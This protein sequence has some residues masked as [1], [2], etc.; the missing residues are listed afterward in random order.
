L[1]PLTL[2]AVTHRVAPFST[3]E[4]V[5]LDA[6]AAGT[7]AVSLRALPGVDEAV[8]LSTCNRTELYLAAGPACVDDAVDA[9]AD[10]A[11]VGAGEL[12]RIAAVL[13]D[14]DASRHLFRVAAGLES[15]VVGEGE[16]LAQVRATA[17]RAEGHPASGPGLNA[18]FRWAAA[19][20]R[21][22]RRDAGGA[23]PP[24]L[25]RTAVD[26]AGPTAP[27]ERTVVLGAG[28]MA[29]A[30]AAELRARNRPYVVAARRPERAATLTR[31]PDDAVHLDDVA[32]HLREATVVVCATA[33]RTP[34]LDAA[35]VGDGRRPL[36][37][38]DLSMPRNVAADVGALDGVRLLDLE[39]LRGGGGDLHVRRAGD[40]VAAE[41]D[42]YRLWLAGRAAGPV[43]AAL[44]RR[45]TDLC[46]DEARRHLDPPAAAAFARRVAGR[47]LHTP[48]VAIKRLSEQGDVAAIDA[49]GAAL[50]V[51]RAPVGDVS[52]AR[53]AS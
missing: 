5:A 44:R 38:V 41:H 30:V 50:G 34:V 6:D 7:L 14:D 10:H 48:T 19:T 3:L 43:I 52:A 2:V 26:A 20:G 53:Q 9:L 46:L 12:R 23:V 8:V 4:R 13:T 1:R 29:A 22:A 47:V 28:A 42:R 33:A 24:S 51:D 25:A 31:R 21:R 49:L 39:H 27:G 17:A 45:V 37:V 18:L 16:I 36:T 35:L 40:V 11:G 15:R 32:A